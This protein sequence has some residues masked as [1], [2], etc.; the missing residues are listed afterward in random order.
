MLPVFG[1]AHLALT[2]WLLVWTPPPSPG[3]W[4]Y[5]DALGKLTLLSNSVATGNEPVGLDQD[6]SGNFVLAVNATGSTTFDAYYFDTTTA[7][8]LDLGLSSTS[9]GTS[10][11]TVVAEP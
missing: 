8:K 10:P 7:G 6:L 3:G 9:T 4:I 5:L 11:V 1:L 2:A